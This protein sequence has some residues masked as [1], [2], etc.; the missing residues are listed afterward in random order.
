[1]TNSQQFI[2]KCTRQSMDI[3]KQIFNSPILD[4][5]AWSKRKIIMTSEFVG[6][7]MKRRVQYLLT[8]LQIDFSDQL[9]EARF[10]IPHKKY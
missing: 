7:P 4:L 9:L 1:M 10:L 3:A 5:V 2:E 6:I 8:I